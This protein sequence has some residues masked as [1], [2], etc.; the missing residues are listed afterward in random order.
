MDAVYRQ[1]VKRLETNLADLMEENV[2]LREDLASERRTHSAQL[3]NMQHRLESEVQEVVKRQDLVW[4]HLFVSAS[5]R[6]FLVIVWPLSMCG[7]VLV[8]AHVEI[9]VF[10]SNM[11]LHVTA[12]TRMLEISAIQQPAA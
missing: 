2:K 8:N 7:L 11:R 12:C 4:L 6:P 5:P 10:Q 9:D 3:S 1:R